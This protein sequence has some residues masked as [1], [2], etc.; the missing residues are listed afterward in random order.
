MIFINILHTLLG[1]NSFGADQ[2]NM[3]YNQSFSEPA[4]NSEIM[5][6]LIPVYFRVKPKLHITQYRKR[7]RKS[8]TIFTDLQLRVLEK[9][10]SEQRYLDST[11]RTKLSHILCLNEVQVKTWFQNRR[12]KWKREAQKTEKPHSSTTAK[13]TD[14]REQALG[15][16][17][18]QMN[19]QMNA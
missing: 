14:K 6:H 2:E 12:R 11:N 16:N 5:H 15:E 8:R 19:Q 17:G 1:N 4:T 3:F 10:F 18:G 9:T 13:K 7:C